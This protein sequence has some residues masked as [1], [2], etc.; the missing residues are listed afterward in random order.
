MEGTSSL[1]FANCEKIAAWI[2]KWCWHVV[3]KRIDRC[4]TIQYA[5]FY[6]IKYK[7]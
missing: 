7:E 5:L 3:D 4:S 1:V 2:R 6:D